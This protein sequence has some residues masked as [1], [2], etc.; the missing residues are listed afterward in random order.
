MSSDKPLMSLENLANYFTLFVVGTVTLL[1]SIFLKL[2]VTPSYI[3]LKLGLFIV[4]ILSYEFVL[5][6]LIMYQISKAKNKLVDDFL[7]DREKYFIFVVVLLAITYLIVVWFNKKD[8]IN[9]IQNAI[10]TI[11]ALVSIPQ[12]NKR[13]TVWWNKLKVKKS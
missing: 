13:I 5:F 2:P 7:Q 6:S 4:T 9:L 11:I 1:L 3:N 12:V 8:V 10:I